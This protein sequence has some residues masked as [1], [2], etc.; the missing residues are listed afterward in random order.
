[1]QFKTVIKILVAIYALAVTGVLV[2]A[3]TPASAAPR[4]VITVRTGVT[5]GQVFDLLTRFVNGHDARK[6]DLKV[7][8]YVLDS[9]RDRAL[10]E[11]CGFDRKGNQLS[12]AGDHAEAVMV[13]EIMYAPNASAK[14]SAQ[15]KL[16]KHMGFCYL[17][18]TTDI[19][20]VSD[21]KAARVG[22]VKR[23]ALALSKMSGNVVAV[24][25]GKKVTTY[26]W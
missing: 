25:D 19:G 23:I 9:T 13:G 10:T 5:D 11:P 1:M 22:A 16:S 4:Q 6:S 14:R 8:R 21:A 18:V 3:N 17:A 2:A 24:Q 12:E 15:R 20:G 7:V 26:A